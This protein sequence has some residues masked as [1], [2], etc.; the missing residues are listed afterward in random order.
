MNIEL[1]T[2]LFCDHVQAGG[3]TRRLFNEEEGYKLSFSPKHGVVVVIPGNSPPRV[4]PVSS[5]AWME[6]KDFSKFDDVE[7]L[8]ELAAEEGPDVGGEVV[9]FPPQKKKPGRPKKS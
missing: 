7:I 9:I 4:I 5:V 8:A 6:P 1:K 3:A 2:V